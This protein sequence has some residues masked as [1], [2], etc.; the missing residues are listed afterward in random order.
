MIAEIMKECNNHFW[1][2][3]E[4][5]MYSIVSDGIV[6][7]FSEKYIP[8]QYIHLTGS[9]LNDGVYKLTAV[10]ESKLTVEEGLK[11]EDTGEYFNVYGCKVPTE[12]L[13]LVTDIESWASNNFDKSG[14]A[15]ESIDG[16]SVNF[17]TNPDGTI[18][19]NWKNAFKTQLTP[20]R[21]MF[22]SWCGNGH[23]RLL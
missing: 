10:S 12:F 21:Q 22:E 3:N 7:K 15:S 4:R 1:R 23:N 2:S 9:F 5:R 18:G 20:Y 11:A 14:I 17:A 19:N 13:T 8:G 6:G 16:Y